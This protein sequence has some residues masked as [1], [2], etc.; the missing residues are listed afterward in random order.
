MGNSSSSPEEI[1]AIAQKNEGYTLPLGAPNPT[2]P[3]VY[4]DVQLG[5][6]FI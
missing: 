2:N 3:K 6:F 1:V 4:M 5:A